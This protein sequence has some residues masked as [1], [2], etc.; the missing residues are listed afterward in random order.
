MEESSLVPQDREEPK[1]VNVG[2]V[3]VEAFFKP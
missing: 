2:P 1:E 3:D